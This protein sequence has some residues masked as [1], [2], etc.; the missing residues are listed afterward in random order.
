M[1]VHFCRCS[2]GSRLGRGWKS[3]EVAVARGYSLDYWQHSFSDF[4]SYHRLGFALWMVRR[5]AAASLARRN[6]ELFGSLVFCS[7]RLPA[8]YY[9]HTPAVVAG[10]VVV[11][12]VVVLVF[13]SPVEAAEWWPP[14]W[15]PS[16]SY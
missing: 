13:S 8:F 3:A 14:L 6:W 1:A 4:S 16:R 2:K 7:D 5:R 12:L 10:F 15:L 11:R 9:Y